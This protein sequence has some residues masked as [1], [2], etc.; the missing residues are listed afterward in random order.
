[1]PFGKFAFFDLGAVY[2]Y[3]LDFRSIMFLDLLV[4]HICIVT[5]DFFTKR[6]ATDFFILSL[7]FGFFLAT[8]IFGAITLF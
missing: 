5:F 4:T 1:M 2:F 8:W 6:S 7:S 3:S